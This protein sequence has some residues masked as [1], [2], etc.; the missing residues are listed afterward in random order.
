MELEE[1]LKGIQGLLEE[2]SAQQGKAAV[3]F[4]EMLR[5]NDHAKRLQ[6]MAITKLMELRTYETAK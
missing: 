1:K 3:L 6:L 4:E 5:A 2:S